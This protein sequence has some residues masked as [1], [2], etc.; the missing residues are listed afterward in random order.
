MIEFIKKVFQNLEPGKDGYQTM[1]K[2]LKEI[3]IKDKVVRQI[4]KDFFKRLKVRKYRF[5][6]KYWK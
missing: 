5:V 4:E 1:I 2:T 3:G 6:K